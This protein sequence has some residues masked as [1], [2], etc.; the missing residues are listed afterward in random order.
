MFNPNN[1]FW[2]GVSRAGD[3]IWLNVLFC[4]AAL[5]VVTGGAAITALFDV[6]IRVDRGY[7]PSINRAFWNAFRANFKQASLIW[8]VVSPV[9]ALVIASWLLLPLEQAT[10]L[11]VLTTLLYL[12]VFPY[13]FFLQAKFENTVTGTIKNGLLIP[14]LRLPYTLGALAIQVVLV[15]VAVATVKYVPQALPLLL[16]FGFAG[17]AYAVTPVLG[18]SV[19]PWSE[20]PSSVEDPASAE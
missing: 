1:A 11:R 14:L 17:A 2:R 19:K 13:F 12:A 3:L 6:L 15:A 18:L 8:L 20:P 9:G 5:P 10:A 16:L 4:V 7:E